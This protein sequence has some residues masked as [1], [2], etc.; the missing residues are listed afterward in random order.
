MN[1][2]ALLLALAACALADTA[3]GARASASSKAAKTAAAAPAANPAPAP[4]PALARLIALS[5]GKSQLLS[6]PFAASR[7]A[8]GDA[9][10]ADVILLNPNEVYL[11]GKRP[12]T[13]NLILWNKSNDATIID[14]AVGIDS[15]SLQ[16]RMAEL[17]PNEKIHVTVAGDTLILSGMVSD[18]VKADQALSLA[19]AYVQRSSRSGSADSQA[20][21]MVAS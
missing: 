12:G 2:A 9:A 14:L 18:V 13:T 20:P 21:L 8:V 6:L 19:N 3:H 4:A 7:L 5:A 11:L 15:S 1:R 17:L 10:I 16:A